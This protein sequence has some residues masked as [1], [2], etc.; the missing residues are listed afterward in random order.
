MSDIRELIDEAKGL[1]VFVAVVLDDRSH[2]ALLS[3]WERATGTKLLNKLYAHHMTIK[4]KP[5]QA[6]MDKLTEGEDVTLQVIG[7]A[8]DGKVQAVAVKGF[9]S[10]NKIPHITVATD[11]T[12]PRFSNDL[13]EKGYA[14]VRGPR[15]K[16]T[17]HGQRR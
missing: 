6:D 16:G 12:A 15:L 17:I 9:K 10:A 11:G 7:W 4:F 2:K 3:W 1:P 13:L 8:E 5:T 14:R